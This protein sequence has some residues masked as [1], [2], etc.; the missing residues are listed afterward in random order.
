MIFSILPVGI[1]LVLF[2][3]NVNNPTALDGDVTNVVLNGLNGVIPPVVISLFFVGILAAAMSSADSDI[4]G[5]ASI[6]GNDIY[7]TY[8]NKKPTESQ[9]LSAT[10][11][12]IIIVGIS[13]LFVALF[14]QTNVIQ[15]LMLSFTLRAGGVFI[16]YILGHYWKDASS[17]GALA[18]IIS[19]SAVV[20][21][22]EQ[23]GKS[24][25]GFGPAV[26]SVIVSL[27]AF[28]LFSKLIPNKTSSTTLKEKEKYSEDV[29]EFYIKTDI[30]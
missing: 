2:Y 4:F 19:G 5:A 15:I 22:M 29:E 23:S 8:I 10:R 12:I 27:I 26:P 30:F 16:P 17:A 11:N 14:S 9:A 7:R 13:A 18:A 24:I 6:I 20:I 21:V 25:L 1:G 3:N 28:V